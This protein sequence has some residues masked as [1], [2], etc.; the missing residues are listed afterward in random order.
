MISNRATLSENKIYLHHEQLNQN[1]LSFWLTGD[2]I[3]SGMALNIIH[4]IQH[5]E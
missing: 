4:I 1:R 2:D 5:L 3:Q